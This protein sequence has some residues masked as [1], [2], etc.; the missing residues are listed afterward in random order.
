MELKFEGES[1]FDERGDRTE[2]G[3]AGVEIGEGSG[4]CGDEGVGFKPQFGF[5]LRQVRESDAEISKCGAVVVAMRKGAGAKNARGGII[6]L[7]LED[8]IERANCDEKFVTRE[9]VFG[10]GEREAGVGGLQLGGEDEIVFGV[11]PAGLLDGAEGASHIEFGAGGRGG[12][13]CGEVGDS[14]VSAGVGTD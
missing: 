3:N 10:A 8:G 4:G 14:N 2:A 13:K 11:G 1:G 7:S 12:D 5:G 6:G 9:V